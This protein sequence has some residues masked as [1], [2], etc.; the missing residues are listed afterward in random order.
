MSRRVHDEWQKAARVAARGE[1][2]VELIC[3][4]TFDSNRAK[5]ESWIDAINH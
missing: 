1:A 4:S 3:D 5:H 2:G